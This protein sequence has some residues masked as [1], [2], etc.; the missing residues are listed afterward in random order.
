MIPDRHATEAEPLSR[1]S[2]CRDAGPEMSCPD[3]NN[4]CDYYYYDYNYYCY[5][6]HGPPNILA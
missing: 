3:D 5:Y 4:N 6:Y 1:Q 2:T